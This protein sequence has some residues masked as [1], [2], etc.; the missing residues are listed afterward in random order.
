[1]FLTD[2][3]RDTEN[4]QTYFQHGW[5][6]FRYSIRI[7]VAGV[8]G[9]VHAIFPW[10]FKFYTAEQ[11][12]KSYVGVSQSGRHDDLL[13]KYGLKKKNPILQSPGVEVIVIDES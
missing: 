12:I 6:A 8:I 2:H 10:W 1:M 13:E 4:P 11:I 7:T 3:I 9:I 5:F